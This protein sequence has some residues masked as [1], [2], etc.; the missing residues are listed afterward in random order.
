MKSSVCL[1]MPSSALVDSCLKAS[2]NVPGYKQKKVV[3]SQGSKESNSP[4]LQLKLWD[5]SEKLISASI[6]PHT[7]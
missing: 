1:R 3:R 5:L 6:Q 7:A 2:A 4:E